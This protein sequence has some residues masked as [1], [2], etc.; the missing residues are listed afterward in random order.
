MDA[1][2]LAF[3]L[4]AESGRAMVGRLRSGVLD[5]DEISSVSQRAGAGGSVAALGSSAALARNA[6]GPRDGGGPHVAVDSIGVDTWGCDYG[7]LGRGRCARSATRI[8]T[9]TRARTASWI[10]VFARVSRSRIYD[11]TGI[12]FLPFNTI[13]QLV[14]A[15]R[16]HARLAGSGELVRD[17]P[18]HPELLAHRRP[19]RRVH[20]RD[21][22]ADGRRED[23]AVGDSLL[24]EL[25][26]PAEL[27][28]PLVEPGT[29]LG[30]LK[31]SA[32][33]G[34]RARPS[35][36]PRVTTPDR[37]WQRCR[38][39]RTRAFLSSGTWSLLG[40]EVPEPVIT[41][42]GAGSEFHQRGRRRA[43]RRGCSRTSA[44]CGCCR[45][46]GAAG[47]AMGASTRTPN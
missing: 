41:A 11:I 16:T 38:A 46:A 17:D 4:G 15:R 36:R 1:N 10:D 39:S 28:P 43:A 13:Y 35:S 6:E 44:G 27:L 24:R 18:R 8:T 42:R 20:E 21:H 30:E 45:R 9:A 25:D 19:A 3:D 37:R 31:S 47:R 22:D 5:L 7:L 26:L 33:A 29:V 32:C 34:S 12:Q 2:Y 14:A 40:I 23:E